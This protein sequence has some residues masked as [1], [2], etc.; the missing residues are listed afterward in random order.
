MD[1]KKIFCKRCGIKTEHIKNGFGEVGGLLVNARYECLM[2]R[3][4]NEE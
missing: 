1:K 3:R 2:C 4:N